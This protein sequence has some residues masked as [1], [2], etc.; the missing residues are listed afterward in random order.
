MTRYILIVLSAVVVCGGIAITAQAP[1]NKRAPILT[2]PVTSSV[3]VQSQY[4]LDHEHLLYI[5]EELK[6]MRTQTDSVQVIK[7][8]AQ[9][10]VW[11]VG[12][13][14]TL[15]ISAWL[16]Y[17][18]NHKTR[19]G[20][21]LDQLRKIETTIHDEQHVTKMSMTLLSKDIVNSR[22]DLFQ[23]LGQVSIEIIQAMTANM[24]QVEGNKDEIKKL[25][26]MQSMLL[27]KIRRI[28][29]KEIVEG[30]D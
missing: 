8:F 2:A 12:V 19:M 28:Q 5:T 21:I 26:T 15:V 25:E 7:Y 17:A 10:C 24:K 18:R 9:A 13:F 14:G 27:E 29:N 20:E 6:E 16:A 1:V 3:E 23:V 30:G 4:M 22:H 11:V